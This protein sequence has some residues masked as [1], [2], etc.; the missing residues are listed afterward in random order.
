MNDLSITQQ[1]VLLLIARYQSENDD[2]YP[3]LRELIDY[4]D[5][6]V[7]STS[8]VNY[9]LNDL[10]KLGYVERRVQKS[11]VRLSKKGKR[12]IKE[13][14]QPHYRKYIQPWRA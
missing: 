9:V 14:G 2:W 3:T 5:S 7:S 1:R 11:S 4:P 10:M 8:S 6:P 13:H 12:A